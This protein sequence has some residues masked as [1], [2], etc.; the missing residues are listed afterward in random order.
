MTHIIFYE[1]QAQLDKIICH[2]SLVSYIKVRYS[3][4]LMLSVAIVFKEN[5]HKCGVGYLIL[6]SIFSRSLL[7]EYANG[8]PRLWATLFNLKIQ[9][10]IFGVLDYYDFDF[11]SVHKSKIKRKLFNRLYADEYIIYGYFNPTCDLLRPLSDYYKSNVVLMKRV[12]LKKIDQESRTTFPWALYVGQPWAEVGNYN[13]EETQ[14]KLYQLLNLGVPNT[15]FC[16]HPRQTNVQIPKVINGWLHLKDFIRDNGPPVLAISLNSSLI[17][18]LK[19]MGI[20][21]IPIASRVNGQT[22]F[23]EINEAI[24]KTG[25]AISSIG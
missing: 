7:C 17:Y 13:N 2:N 16:V 25:Y 9:S 20:K 8:L 4:R 1:D 11:N 10:H 12:D 3:G 18:E 19:E 24:E 14:N 22:I 6:R 5:E 23:H 21:A 15:Y